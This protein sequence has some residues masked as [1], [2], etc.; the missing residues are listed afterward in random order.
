M[1][2]KF[3]LD[4]HVIIKLTKSFASH[5]SLPKEGFTEYVELVKAPEV[6]PISTH[7]V[8]IVASIGPNGYYEKPPYPIKI[9]ENHKMLNSVT[10]KS[11]KKN[12]TPYEQVQVHPHIPSIK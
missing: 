11:A 5:L 9:K 6:V 12:C 4:D 7:P 10:R 1:S 3:N 8:E 2:A